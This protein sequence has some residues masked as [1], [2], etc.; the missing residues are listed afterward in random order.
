MPKQGYVTSD[1]TFAS[2]AT[3]EVSLGFSI[4]RMSP[5]QFFVFPTLEKLL[6]KKKNAVPSY[7]QSSVRL[8]HVIHE[9]YAG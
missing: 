2:C 4:L 5:R 6:E 1:Y 9:S 8:L 3:L 7:C